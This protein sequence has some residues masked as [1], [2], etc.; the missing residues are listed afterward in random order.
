MFD[1]SGLTTE[2]APSEEFSPSFKTALFDRRVHMPLDC[3]VESVRTETGE[4]VSVEDL[5]RFAA[6]GWF[7]SGQNTRTP[8]GSAVCTCT[9]TT[10]GIIQARRSCCCS[11][12]ATSCL[13]PS[14]RCAPVNGLAGCYVSTIGKPHEYFDLTGTRIADR[15]V[16]LPGQSVSP[17]SN[18]RGSPRPPG[19]SPGVQNNRPD[20]RIQSQQRASPRLFDFLR[21]T[22]GKLLDSLL[23]ETLSLSEEKIGQ[24]ISTITQELPDEPPGSPEALTEPTSAGASSE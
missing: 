21:S 23:H 19:V 12:P 18:W 11:Q 8:S 13:S 5:Q 24:D 6:D 14:A 9:I 7:P 1:L 16:S 15:N 10:R 17:R 20:I 4:R 3:L 22:K 2:P